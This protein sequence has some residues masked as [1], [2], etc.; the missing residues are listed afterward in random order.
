MKILFLTQVLPYPLDAGPKTRAY[1]VLRHLAA[2]GHSITLLSFT[3]DTDRPENV[4]HLRRFCHAVHTVRI[5]RTKVRDVWELL[6]SLGTRKPFLVTRDW[7]PEMARN[8]RLLVQSPEPFDVVHADQLWMAPY[9]LLARDLKRFTPPHS[10]ILDQ[11]NAVFQVALRLAGAEIN[12]LKRSLLELEAQKLKRYETRVCQEFDR[13]V[14]VTAEDRGAFNQHRIRGSGPCHGSVIPICIDPEEKPVVTRHNHARRIT[15]LGG[16]HWPPNSNGI[17]WFVHEIWPEVSH[18]VPDAV[19]TIIGKNSTRQLSSLSRA[20]GNVEVTGYV[21]DLMPFL[22]ETAV[23]I[24]PLLAGGGM[25]VKMLD[26]WA[27]GLPVVTTP[28][29]AEG[30]QVRKGNNVLLADTPMEFANAVIAVLK[31]PQLSSRLVRQGRQTLENHYD[32]RKVYQA[33]DEVYNCASSLSF[34]TLPA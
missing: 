15:F 33:W 27:W 28:I 21:S 9:A 11:H 10:I 13:V 8:I 12:P 17:A 1:Y 30:I 5:R 6:R 24:I 20:A 31:N 19:L 26:A 25:R 29:G 22:E 4:A 34:H 3:R 16:L 23:F 7:S 32:W 14:W 2:C 18:S